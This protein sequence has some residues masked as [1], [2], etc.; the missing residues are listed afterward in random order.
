MNV[1]SIL[2]CTCNPALDTLEKVLK[3]CRKQTFDPGKYEIILVDNNSANPLS[4]V[5]F[6]KDIPA[7][8]N[9]KLIEEK[10]QGLAYARIA[11]SK[12]ANSDTFVFVDDDN[13]LDANYLQNLKHLQAQYPQVAAWGPGVISIEYRGAVPDWVK[14]NYSWLF[15]QKNIE[16]TKFGSVA[17]WPDYY[18]AGSGLCVTRAVMEKYIHE[19]EKGNLTLTG[20]T[21]KILSSAEDTQIVW[22]AVKIGLSAGT[23][24]LLMLRHVIPSSRTS[25]AYLKAL[26]YGVA[27]SY[28][29]ALKEM[30][31]EK[32]G[33]LKKR[34]FAGKLNFAL[35]ML[36]KARFKPLAFYRFYSIENSWYRAI[37]NLQSISG[38]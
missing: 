19:F 29:T 3:S 35:R 31:P 20:R 5:K 11:G 34:S 12:A 6:I 32:T 26:N 25:L 18:P 22:T 2:I 33:S 14:T 24:P 37:E 9:F 30:F 38:V 15:Q 4:E 13:V 8:S 36:L 1:F 21:G 7:T 27:I 23:S 16:E 28:A 17:G 10:T